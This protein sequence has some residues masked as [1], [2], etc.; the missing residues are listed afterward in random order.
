[1]KYDRIHL[2]ACYHLMCINL[3]PCQRLVR[4]INC[5]CQPIFNTFETVWDNTASWNNDCPSRSRQNCLEII[6][7]EVTSRTYCDIL[8]KLK[9]KKC[10]IR[11][12]F[13]LQNKFSNTV[14]NFKNIHDPSLEHCRR[15]NHLDAASGFVFCSKLNRDVTTNLN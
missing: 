15:N 9:I 3:S 13:T 11:T 6:C 12:L 1:M 14:K 5:F 10:K 4:K 7:L 2:T 8:I